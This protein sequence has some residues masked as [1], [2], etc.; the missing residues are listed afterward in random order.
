MA[1]LNLNYDVLYGADGLVRED[2][3]ATPSANDYGAIFVAETRQATDEQFSALADY[4]NAGGKLIVMGSDVLRYD[5]LG[6]D[7][8]ASRSLGSTTYDGAFGAV[9]ETSYG[10]G[11]VEVVSLNPLASNTYSYHAEAASIDL[12]AIRASVSAALPE[13]LSTTRL[14]GA[15]RLRA[16][17]YQDD[18]DSSLIVHLVNHAF[19]DEGSALA[20]HSDVQITTYL[21]TNVPAGAV[22]NYVTAESGTF[23]RSI[24][25]T[26][27]MGRLPSRFP[28][29][30]PGV[31]CVLAL[32][33]MPAMPNIAPMAELTFLFDREFGN[34]DRNL[35]F[36]PPMTEGLKR[37]FSV[38]TIRRV[39][40]QLG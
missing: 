22:A 35:V 29:L 31:F 10:S 9:G 12:S 7:R 33:S 32:R 25:L 6:R 28:P 36:K 21:P 8:A 19:S 3:F 30:P 13:G 27:G 38:P 1:G 17:T 18:G 26:M 2:T 14:S 24:P 20:T 37:S 16:L 23:S 4:V 39:E 11:S 40:R 15:D 5:E 34:P